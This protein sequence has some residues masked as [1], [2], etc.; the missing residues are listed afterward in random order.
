MQDKVD[1]SALPPAIWQPM[2][3]PGKR[4]TQFIKTWHEGRSAVHAVADSSVSMFRQK[5]RLEP[6]ALGVLQFSW[7]SPQLI[8]SADMAER[9]TEDSVVRIVLSF[10]G[11]RSK[12]SAKNKMLSEL[13]LALTG[14]ELPYATLMYVWCNTR[15]VGDVIFN[16]RTERIRKI[17]VESG[18]ANLGKWLDYERDIRADFIKAFGEEPGVLT[19]IALMTDTDNTQSKATAW[20][21][22]VSFKANTS[23]KAP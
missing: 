14:E 8:P 16:P 4:K 21:G 10:D 11:D 9:E 18:A 3:L 6:G 20:Y 5:M 13:S 23:A 19:G 2:Y 22:P 15:A 12:F 7:Q 1:A 17:V